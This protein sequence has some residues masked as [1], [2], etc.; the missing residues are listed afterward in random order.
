MEI[1]ND[2]SRRS[3]ELKFR[4][5][6][7]PLATVEVDIE[8]LE[9]A[10]K[11][12]PD[13]LYESLKLFA[14]S[15]EECRASIYLYETESCNF[16]SRK[17]ELTYSIF[18][19]VAGGGRRVHNVL[20]KSF[21]S[22]KGVNVKFSDSINPNKSILEY[23]IENG[24]V[25]RPYEAG[26]PYAEKKSED[27][28]FP[29]EEE[30]EEKSSNEKPSR[31]RSARKDATVRSIKKQIESV[32]RLPEGSVALLSSDGS[33]LRA[34]AKIGTL[35]QR[36][37]EEQEKS[38]N[39]KSFRRRSARKDATVGSIKKQIESVFGLPEGSVALLSRDG[40]KL[41]ADA[42]IGTLRQ[43]WDD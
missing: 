21:S 42:K 27:L 25:W 31:C 20:Y 26:V 22:I 2:H 28:E 6:K 40:S 8:S 36:F 12:F 35:R 7:R 11:D 16:I 9:E 1:N 38:S 30:E 18:I 34:N 23:H 10:G 41:R 19:G 29:I 4:R 37:E 32:F 14:E 24:L 39:E 5:S 43:R 15:D 3:D 17:R 13:T 33:E